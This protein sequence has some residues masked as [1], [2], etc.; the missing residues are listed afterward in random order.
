MGLL[1]LCHGQ[2]VVLNLPQTRLASNL[3]RQITDVI[4]QH[5]SVSGSGGRL[6][7]C[8]YNIQYVH[9]QPEGATHSVYCWRA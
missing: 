6:S 3:Q 7:L 4:V 5:S 2:A 1:H 8:V 9:A